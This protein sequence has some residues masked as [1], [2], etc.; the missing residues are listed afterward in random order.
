[1]FREDLLI[2]GGRLIDPANG[3][4]DDLDLLIRD[5]LVDCVG[6][7]LDPPAATPVYEIDGLVLTPGFIDSHVHFREPGFEHKETI[8]TG[9]AAA[10]AGGICAVVTMPNTDPP[11]DTAAR[12]A[13]ARARARTAS[14]RV[15]PVGCVTVG[16]AGDSLAP[17]AELAT[18]GAVAFSDDGD[19]VEDEGMMRR[20]LE[21][22]RRADRP[23]FPHEEVKRLT[24]GGSMNA[25]EVSARLGF[26]GMPSAGEEEMV[27]RDIDLVRATSGPL[28]VAHISSAGTV[29]LIRR[30]KAEALPVTC[31]V[32]T[33]HCVLTDEEVVALG[34]AAKMSPPLR[35]ATD[36]EAVLDGLADGT[37]D[38][39]A[40][41]HAPH[42]AAEKA[43]PFEA[44]PMGIV[45]LETAVGLTLT[46]LVHAGIVDL[47]AAVA[48]W[49][50]APARALRLPGGRLDPGQPGDA[51]VLDLDQRWKV[52]PSQFRSKSTNTPFEGYELTGRAAA[53]IV[54]GRVMFGS[55]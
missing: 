31:E 17:I 1:M 15:Y 21:Q 48:R 32:L 8:A 39:L 38:T 30:A 44:A 34:T 54:G 13:D 19:P 11:P 37:I 3:I 2:R 47:S 23:I 35:T 28:H 14:A 10:V 4:D 5:G 22:A 42:T 36:V 24:A 50:S 12:I 7:N 51:T 27:S 6:H 9:T 43:V 25:G 41:D 53:T 18:A 55:R 52:D 29:D 45:G 49:T 46:Y 33:H 16:R 40:T 26:A 20:A